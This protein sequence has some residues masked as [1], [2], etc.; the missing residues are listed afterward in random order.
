M[1]ARVDLELEPKAR[2]EQS[3]KN[4]KTSK[5]YVDQDSLEPRYRSDAFRISS[6]KVRQTLDP[7]DVVPSL[8]C[9]L[10]H[11][12]EYRI[13]TVGLLLSVSVDLL[14]QRC[15]E[16]EVWCDWETFD[17][18]PAAARV[19]SG[20]IH[21]CIWGHLL[22]SFAAGRPLQQTVLPRL[23]DLPGKSQYAAATSILYFILSS[24]LLLLLLVS[25]TGGVVLN[26]L[27]HGGAVCTPRRESPPA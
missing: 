19:S 13:F 17:P 14:S 22:V 18:A 11:R 4:A 25:T 2:Q 15:C 9:P 10:L 27:L 3:G 16:G 1:E 20:L 23:D 5:Q 24:C 12:V 7:Q 6:Y 8:W 26:C 21:L